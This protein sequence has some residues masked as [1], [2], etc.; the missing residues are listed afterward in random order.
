MMN[1]CVVRFCSSVTYV[2]KAIHSKKFENLSHTFTSSLT[3]TFHHKKTYKWNAKKHFLFQSD[4]QFEKKKKIHAAKINNMCV[5]I[6]SSLNLNVILWLKNLICWNVEI[7]WWLFLSSIL[8]LFLI[9]QNWYL[10]K[11]EIHCFFQSWLDDM[12]NVILKNCTIH[13][14]TMFVK[15]SQWCHWNKMT[16]PSREPDDAA[17]V[18]NNLFKKLIICVEN[19]MITSSNLWFI[20]IN[21]FHWKWRSNF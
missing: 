3:E 18:K 1:Q 16:L 9:E 15:E 4:H 8:N 11:C 6:E 17:K 20:I 2:Y 5:H 10:K 13:V 12:W 19:K 14:K 7:L 21:L